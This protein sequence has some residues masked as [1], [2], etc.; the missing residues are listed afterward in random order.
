MYRVRFSELAVEG[1]VVRTLA[2]LLRRERVVVGCALLGFAL[3]GVCAGV[4]GVRGS[5]S[6][7][8]EGRL[9]DALKFEVGVGIYFLTLAM[10]LPLARMS[11]R[12]RRW[13]VGWTAVCRP[14]RIKV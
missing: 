5:W 2:A 6:V 3:A 9:L 8:P 10:M 7:P 13:W 14:C 12:G 11:E 1:S 4:A